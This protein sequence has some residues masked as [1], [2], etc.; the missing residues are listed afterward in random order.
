MIE[1]I[2]I[3]TSSRECENVQRTRSIQIRTQIEA[4]SRFG[5]S[6]GTIRCLKIATALK[7]V[8]LH[9][10][11]SQDRRSYLRA[12]LISPKSISAFEPEFV[13]VQS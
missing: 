2:P 3:Q 6:S 4:I 9:L 5:L 13:A 1:D 8:F 7:F 11:R 10:S 12:K